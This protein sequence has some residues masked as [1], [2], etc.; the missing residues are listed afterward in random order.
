MKL[1]NN[2]KFHTWLVEYNMK[3]LILKM[4]WQFLKKLDIH[5]QYDSAIPL[6][7]IYLWEMKAYAHTKTRTPMTITVLSLIEKKNEMNLMGS[8]R[9]GHD[10]RNLAAA[11][12]INRRMDKPS[13]V[14][15]SNGMLLSS[16]LNELLKHTIIWMNL[17]IFTLSEMTQDKRVGSVWYNV[18]RILK[19]EI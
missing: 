11:M 6:L 15:P 1:W 5:W 19:N 8:H 13:R 18:Y 7:N 3:Q 17:K 10:W 12:Y 9:V 14:Y 2:K 4:V 16:K